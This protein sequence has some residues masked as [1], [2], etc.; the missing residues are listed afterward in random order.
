M[1]LPVIARGVKAAA[2]LLLCSCGKTAEEPRA[3]PTS[4]GSAS[5]CAALPRPEVDAA[6]ATE[7]SPLPAVLAGSLCD[8]NDALVMSLELGIDANSGPLRLSLT[9]GAGSAPY[10]VSLWG[11]DE[12]GERGALA[13]RQET[14]QL[15]LSVARPELYGAVTHVSAD[16]RVVVQLVGPPGPVALQIEQ[17]ERP[18]TLGCGAAYELLPPSSPALSLPAEL[19]LELCSARDSRVFGLE[20]VAGRE[21]MM[22]LENPAAI[23]SF[24]AAFVEAGTRDYV[25]L[26]ASFGTTRDTLGLVGRSMIR[27][28]P[29]FSGS[30]ALICSLGHSRGERARLRVEQPLAELD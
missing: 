9:E 8:R 5:T 7:P 14:S 21:V 23:E 20:G 25:E 18:P 12:Q 27:F 4:A 1:K 10:L 29:D 3:E 24:H 28:T 17:P 13:T 26:P 19:E 15:A 16:P 2:L 30:V 11:L 22:T 6:F